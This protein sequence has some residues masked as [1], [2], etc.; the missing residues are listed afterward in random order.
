MTTPYSYKG[1]N[2]VILILKGNPG[3]T[4]YDISFKG[5]YGSYGSDPQRSRFYSA[6]DDSEV[7]DPNA[8][9]IGYS[10]STMWLEMLKCCLPMQ[11]RVLQKLLMICRCI[12]PN[13]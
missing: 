11:V 8:V 13:P 2:L 10:G 5:T 4:S 9:P 6:F 12:Y 7:L 3:S 1:G